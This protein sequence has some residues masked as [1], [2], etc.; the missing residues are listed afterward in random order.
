MVCVRACACVCVCVTEYSLRKKLKLIQSCTTLC[1]LMDCSPPGSSI[2]GVFQ[3]RVLK[4][5]AFPSPGDLPDPGIEP[6][7]PTLQADALPSEPPGKPR[8]TYNA[9]RTLRL[10]SSIEDSRN[11]KKEKD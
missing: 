1:D 8:S 5:V 4:W 3:A 10:F 6:G 2:H 11:R 7:S 9:S